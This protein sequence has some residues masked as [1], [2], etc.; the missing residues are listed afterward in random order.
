MT[1]RSILACR[2]ARGAHWQLGP[3]PP[4]AGSLTL[5]GWMHAANEQDGG[6]PPDVADVL[7]RAL[8]SVAR[9]TFPS[10]RVSASGAQIWSSFDGGLVRALTDSGV[11][12]RTAAKLRGAPSNG[13]LISTRDAELAARAFDD[14]GFPWWLQG[15]VL[16]L[17]SPDGAPPDVS[18]PTVT[19]LFEDDWAEQA[20][21]LTA[22]DVQGVV[23]PGVDGD[24]AGVLTLTEALEKSL[25]DALEREAR[26]AGLSWAIVP[27]AAL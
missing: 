23:R 2:D 8:T 14:E 16:L 9:V 22:L 5:V 4:P 15:Q 21:R 1:P 24:L 10:S 17:S 12:A 18:A 20:A 25:L 6:V 27:E 26:L 3:L 7:A 19:A 11:V 13:A